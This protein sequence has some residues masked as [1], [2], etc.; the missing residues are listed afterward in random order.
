ML[1]GLLLLPVATGLLP[2]P[3]MPGL[4][5]EVVASTAAGSS[6]VVFGL[7]LG[8][9]ASPAAGAVVSVS[10]APGAVRLRLALVT[11][12]GAAV[13]VASQQFQQQGWGWGWHSRQ[14]LLQRLPQVGLLRGRVNDAYLMAGE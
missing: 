4:G 3:A 11:F 7:G 13:E 6:V 5:L 9:L 2:L 14:H 10:L 1:S 12:S 8:L